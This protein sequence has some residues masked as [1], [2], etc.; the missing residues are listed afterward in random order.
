MVQRTEIG[1]AE[2][3]FARGQATEPEYV[4]FSARERS[5]GC[6]LSGPL[7]ASLQPLAET[8][9]QNRSITPI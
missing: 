9:G 7:R 4:S 2:A 1:K 8:V 6:Q 5:I 3:A